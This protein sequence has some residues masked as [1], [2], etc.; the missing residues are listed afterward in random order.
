[1]KRRHLFEWEDQPWLP[2]VSRD[3][4]TDHLRY[5]LESE[6][7]RPIHVASAE[8]LRDAMHRAGKAAISRR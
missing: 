3:F 5:D 6:A 2:T 8:V 4:I 1:M 7:S